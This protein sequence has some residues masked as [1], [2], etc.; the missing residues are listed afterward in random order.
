[1]LTRVFVLL[2]TNS[3][4]NE[5]KKRSL[6]DKKVENQKLPVQ[7]IFIIILNEEIPLYNFG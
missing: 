3:F 6:V 4:L 5:K 1:M 2:F 7:N